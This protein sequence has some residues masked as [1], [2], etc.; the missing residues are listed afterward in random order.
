MFAKVGALTGAVVMCGV[1]VAG[2]AGSAATVK[3]LT[4]LE[5]DESQ[6]AEA[7]AARQ[8]FLDGYFVS[9]YHIETFEGYQAWNGT[10]GT[11]N[12][13][14]TAVGNFTTLGGHG[15]GGSALNGGTALEVR[16]DVPTASGR[17]NTDTLPVSSLGGN[18]LDTNDTYGLQWQ[19]EGVGPFN[20]VAF[21]LIDA[22]DVGA[23]MSMKIGDSTYTDIAQGRRLAN[24]NIHLVL[25]QL[26]EDVSTLT[27]EFLNNK[28]N[29]GFGIDG[30]TVAHI[31]PVPVP[32]AAALLLTGLLGV[33]G[34]RRARRRS[35]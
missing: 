15:T 23:R 26:S 11:S 25:A 31:A 6:L 21:Y 19:V 34:L 30:A 4:I 29:D 32:P 20:M 14:N 5:Y 18:W 7:H 10:S 13:Q 2:S 28:L 27:L 33:A 3:N 17:Y 24:G 9:N 1:L 12:P 16:N 22:V 8:S 35:A